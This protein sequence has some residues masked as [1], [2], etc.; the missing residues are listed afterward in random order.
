VTSPNDR[1]THG[2]HESVLRSHSW[3][4]IANSAAF[5]EPHLVSGQKV[6][7]VGCGP[8]TITLE[9]GERVSPGLVKGIDRSADIIELAQ[10]NKGESKNS[11]VQFEVG[12]TYA[13]RFDDASFDVVYAHQILQHLTDPVAALREMRRVLTPGGLLAVRDSDYDSFVWYPENPSLTRWMNLYH[14]VTRANGANDDA[15]RLLHSW[16]RQAGFS[17][18]EVGSSTWTFQT[19][20]DRRWWGGLWADRV[21]SSAFAEQALE[22]ELS[23]PK[24]LEDIAHGFLEWAEND[25]GLFI[26]VHGEVLAWR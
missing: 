10:Q 3:R 17:A 5:L 20:G 21:R 11:N 9:L 19:E 13:M 16:V 15:G 1:Y 4:T 6:L 26:V 12:D 8:G 23:T 25:D 2:H 14:E 24:E 18:M 7:D 22:Y